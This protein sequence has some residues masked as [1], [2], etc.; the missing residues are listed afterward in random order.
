MIK[1]LLA[2]Q[3]AHPAVILPLV[4]MVRHGVNHVVGK[5]VELV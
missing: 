2:I 1:M 3:N 4:R 5:S